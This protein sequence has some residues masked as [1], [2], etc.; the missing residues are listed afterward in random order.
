MYLGNDRSKRG[1]QCGD[2]TGL[3]QRITEPPVGIKVG[4]RTWSGDKKQERVKIHFEQL[5]ICRPAQAG[6]TLE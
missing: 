2:S 1:R 5:L 6:E 3:Y 4:C